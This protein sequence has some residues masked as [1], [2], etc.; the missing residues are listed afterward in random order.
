M[1]T[2]S[3]CAIFAVV[4]LSLSACT[5]RQAPDDH[6]DLDSVLRSVLLRADDIVE[7]TKERGVLNDMLKSRGLRVCEPGDEGRTWSEDGC[8]TCRCERDLTRAC[9]K[10][11][12]TSDFYLKPPPKQ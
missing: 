5:P 12:C 2:L 4:Q 1:T 9:T 8:N 10:E 11:K 6:S 3:K 7:R